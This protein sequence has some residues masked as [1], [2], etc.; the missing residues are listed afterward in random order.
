MELFKA[1]FI[2]QKTMNILLRV[3]LFVKLVYACHTMNEM[4]Y[5]KYTYMRICTQCHKRVSL[6]PFQSH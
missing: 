2:T 1:K 3:E 4:D 6:H 5:I